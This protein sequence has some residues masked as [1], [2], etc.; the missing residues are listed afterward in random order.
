MNEDRETVKQRIIADIQDKTNISVSWIQR[1]YG[2][3]FPLA[4][5]IY[6]ELRRQ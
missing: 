4:K 5:E 2:I 1:E 6:C 3:G